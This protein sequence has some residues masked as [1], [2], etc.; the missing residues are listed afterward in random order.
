VVHSK[1]TC[2]E[3]R[4]EVTIPA[5]GVKSSVKNFFISRMMYMDDFVLQCKVEGE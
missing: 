1:I 2:P 5:G 3:C 4:Q